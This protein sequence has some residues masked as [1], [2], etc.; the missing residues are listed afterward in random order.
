MT[1]PGMTRHD[2]APAGEQA[3][4]HAGFLHGMAADFA[5]V[6]IGVR[7]MLPTDLFDFFGEAFRG[8][9]EAAHS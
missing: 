4:Q 1:S 9:E 2:D 8:L 5:A 3:G 7:A 6:K